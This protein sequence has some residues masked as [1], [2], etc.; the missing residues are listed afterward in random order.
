MKKCDAIEYKVLGKNEVV[1]CFAW[2]VL[3]F[4]SFHLWVGLSL[5]LQVQKLLSLLV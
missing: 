3:T 1:F 5:M 2:I 4:H